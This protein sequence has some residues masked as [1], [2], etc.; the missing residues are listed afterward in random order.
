[1][2]CRGLILPCPSNSS[3]SFKSI[4]PVRSCLKLPAPRFCFTRTKTFW[5]HT[6]KPK[7]WPRKL[8]PQNFKELQGAR[9]TPFGDSRKL[10]K[11][12]WNAFGLNQLYVQVDHFQRRA[13]DELPTGLHFIAHQVGKYFIGFHRIFDGDLKQE[14]GFRAPSWSPTSDLGSSHPALCSAEWS[15]LCAL[16]YPT[17]RRARRWCRPPTLSDR[18]EY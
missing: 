9:T 4:R 2:T 16:R 1:M 3:W 18:A 5:F 17:S 8:S 6:P 12:P 14:F 7:T 10:S 13:F 11:K 15:S